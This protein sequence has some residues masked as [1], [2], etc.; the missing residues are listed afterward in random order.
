MPPNEGF[1][2]HYQWKSGLSVR[3]WR[4]VVRICNIDKSA[5]TPDAVTGADLPDLCVQA[6]E[7]VKNRTAGRP[8]FYASRTG[9]SR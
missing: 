5:L 6:L 9:K 4:Y 1:R 2:S 7:L 8:A 3:D